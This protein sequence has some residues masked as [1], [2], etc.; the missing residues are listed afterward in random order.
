MN[1]FTFNFG[2]GQMCSDSKVAAIAFDGGL[3]R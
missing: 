3:V 1:K 2:G